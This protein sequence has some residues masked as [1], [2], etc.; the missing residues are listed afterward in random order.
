M[1]K[2]FFSPAKT[3]SRNN[4]NSEPF[5]S[6]GKKANSFFKSAAGNENTFFKPSGLILSQSNVAANPIQKKEQ[7]EGN[8]P[9]E[10]QMKMENSF[11]ADFSK[12][13]I[14]TNSKA[15]EDL[16][17]V[18]YTQGD[19]IHFASKY[20]PYSSQGQEYLGHEL[21]HVVQQNAG[22]VEATHQ[23]QGF[24]VNSDTVLENQADSAGKK[25]ASGQPAG[26]NINNLSKSVNNSSVQKKDA[27]IQLQRES[28]PSSSFI[29]DVN[30]TPEIVLQD[31]IHV[32]SYSPQYDT[33]N[34]R[35]IFFPLIEAQIRGK[36]LGSF[37]H[38]WTDTNG[39]DI[40]W[41]I[42]ISFSLDN[43]T[44]TGRTDSNRPITTSQSGTS[45]PTLG[46]SQT[47]T[48]GQTASA[49]GSVTNA[50]GGVGGGGNVTVGTNDATARSNSQGASAGLTGGQSQSS[51]ETVSRFRAN[52]YT[53]I[54]VQWSAGYS[55]W[56]IINPVKWGAHLAGTQSK[57]KTLHIGTITYDRP[58]Y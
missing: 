5:F 9:D 37:S 20:N 12:V 14:H 44:P 33:V 51:I 18:A 4:E 56:D 52:L 8:L 26:M 34:W 36:Q 54:S 1:A 10:I 30:T 16:N 31:L 43:P 21:S 2:D 17:A 22:I 50:P 41:E 58:N 57:E 15:A 55:N 46:S 24:N 28:I 49:Q 6:K 42:N 13:K 25:A 39:L 23:E 32:A 11:G 27:P 7:K 47:V 29:L 35:Q 38:A 45:T 3:V 19:D 40:D 48:M 53:T